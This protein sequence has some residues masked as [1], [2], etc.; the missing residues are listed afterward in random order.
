MGLQQLQIVRPLLFV[1]LL[2][3]QEQLILTF[4]FLLLTM[5]E[6]DPLLHGETERRLLLLLLRR[7]LLGLMPPEQGFLFLLLLLLFLGLLMLPQQLLLQQAL[8]IGTVAAGDLL[9]L[10]QLLLRQEFLNQGILVATTSDHGRGQLGFGVVARTGNATLVARDT[11]VISFIVTS[12][13]GLVVL[14]ILLAGLFFFFFLLRLQ[15]LGLFG[16]TLFHLFGRG[17]CRGFV[18]WSRNLFVAL[19]FDLIPFLVLGHF[20][21]GAI[22]IG[23]ACGRTHGFPFCGDNHGHGAKELNF[24]YHFRLFFLGGQ[25]LCHLND[26]IRCL[27]RDQFLTFLLEKQ[28]V[29]GR[30]TLIRRATAFAAASFR[31]CGSGRHFGK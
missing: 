4:L 16:M 18:F 7:H 27:G 19:G 9:L 5:Q 25:F 17:W 29:R 23:L 20:F 26:F 10:L 1:L 11:S 28:I 14:E 3:Q 30:R 22:F 8:L 21:T 12:S 2:L 6:F 15:Q 24:A 13:R 31:G